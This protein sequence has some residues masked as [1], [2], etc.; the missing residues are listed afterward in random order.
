MN[1][2]KFNTNDGAVLLDSQVN[3]LIQAMATFSAEN[4]GISWEQAVQDRYHDVQTII[5]AHWQ[6]A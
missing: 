6:A 5:S 3:Q 4:G 2:N 1:V